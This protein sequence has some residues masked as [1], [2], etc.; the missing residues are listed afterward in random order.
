MRIMRFKTIEINRDFNVGLRSEY[1]IYTIKLKYKLQKKFIKD[2]EKKKLQIL[3]I[4]NVDLDF[5]SMRIPKK[6]PWTISI[7]S[8]PV[9]SRKTE[10]NLGYGPKPWVLNY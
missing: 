9:I 8:I 3:T 2:V 7:S 10:Q 5:T 6:K 1:P 4:M